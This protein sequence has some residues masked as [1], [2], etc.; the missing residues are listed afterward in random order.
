[1][2]NE[3]EGLK[4][5]TAAYVPGVGWNSIEGCYRSSMDKI[6]FRRG[7]NWDCGC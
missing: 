6:Q 7:C 5:S 1:M 4:G 3:I 2:L